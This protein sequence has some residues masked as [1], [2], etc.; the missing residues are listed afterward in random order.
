MGLSNLNGEDNTE[1]ITD[2]RKSGRRTIEIISIIGIII[3]LLLLL[4]IMSYCIV[5]IPP[6]HKGVI[7]SGPGKGEQLDEGWQLI[8]PFSKVKNVKY[9][10][11]ICK[12]DISVLADDGYNVVVKTL[13]VYNITENKVAE[14]H[15]ENPDYEDTFIINKLRSTI[16]IHV[17]NSNYTG[18]WLYTNKDQFENEIEEIFTNEKMPNYLENQEIQILEVELPYTIQEALDRQQGN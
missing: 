8:N 14:I 15:I 1:H 18:I 5:H 2:Y 9:I 10:D 13:V 7:V 11:V 3:I 16:R 12:E 17:A 4:I 6:E